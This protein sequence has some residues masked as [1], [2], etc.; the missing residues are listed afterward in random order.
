MAA[1]CL[2]AARAKLVVDLMVS[3][4]QQF[5]FLQPHKQQHPTYTCMVG[6][7]LSLCRFTNFVVSQ[8]GDII[9]H[10]SDMRWA[11]WV[12]MPALQGWAGR[13]DGQLAS[14]SNCRFGVMNEDL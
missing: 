14:C 5:Q 2:W 9:M 3:G 13:D 10:P 4:I 7:P 8:C 6:L 12:K 1:C 11:T